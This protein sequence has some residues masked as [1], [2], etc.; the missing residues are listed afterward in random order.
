MSLQTLFPTIA[1]MIQTGSGTLSTAGDFEVLGL[2]LD[3]AGLS[4]T[5]GGLENF[6]QS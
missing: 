6:T 2:A 4:G 5:V 1:P 3:A